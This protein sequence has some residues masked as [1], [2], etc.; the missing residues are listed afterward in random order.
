VQN[1]SLFERGDILLAVRWRIWL[2]L[3]EQQFRPFGLY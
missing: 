3:E 2:C 1:L